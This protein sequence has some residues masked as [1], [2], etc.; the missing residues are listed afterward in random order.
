MALVVIAG[1]GWR[2]G[3]WRMAD[4]NEEYLKK[5]QEEPPRP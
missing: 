4:V 1:P 3:S 2:D 5:C